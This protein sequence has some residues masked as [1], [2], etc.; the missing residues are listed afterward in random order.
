[1][2]RTSVRSAK[3]TFSRHVLGGWRRTEDTLAAW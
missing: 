1:M 2:T 3:T